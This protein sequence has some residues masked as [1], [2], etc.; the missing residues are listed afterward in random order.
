MNVVS[1]RYAHYIHAIKARDRRGLHAMRTRYNR[2]LKRRDINVIYASFK[3]GD[4]RDI[5]AQLNFDQ[6]G[7]AV[8]VT[9]A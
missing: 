7:R 6:L 1:T 8:N 9:H 3:T 5:S 2:E 4:N